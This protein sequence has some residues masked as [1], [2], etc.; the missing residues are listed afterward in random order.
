MT[1]IARALADALGSDRVATDA[2]SLAAHRTDYWILSHLRARQKRLG[3]GPACVVRP[4]STAEVA[5]A[6]VTA[7]RHGAAV[8][9]YGAGSGVLG[10][11]TPPEGSVVIDLRAMAAVLELNETALWVRVQ[12]GLMGGA[13]EAGLKA[14]GFTGAHFPQSIDVSTVGGWVSTRA[15]GQ[16]STRYGNIEDLLLALEAVLPDGQVVRTKNVPRAAAGP[17]LREV[18]CGSEGTF[19]IVTEVTLRIFPIPERREVASFVFADL[20]D[21]LETIRTVV[22]AGWRPPVLRLYDGTEALRQFS[23]WVPTDRA[24][25]LAVSEGPSAL[26]EGEMVAVARA[27]A[28]AGAQPCGPEPVMH[29]LEHRNRVPSW[30]LFLDKELLVDTIEI[31]ADWDRVAGLYDAVVKALSTVPGMVAASAHSSHSYAQG[32]N[33]Y[34]TFIVK[35]PDFARAEETYLA[36]WTGVME[37]TLAAGGTIAHHH[38]VGRLR[39]S[40]LARELGSAYPVLERLKR[41]LDPTGMM[42]PGVLVPRA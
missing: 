11:A 33:L 29:W 4:R 20:R 7:G 2:D 28:A 19:G 41:M 17:N 30:D 39:T 24:L 14:R 8:V 37:A 21:G 36:A 13:Y 1:D 6:L 15:A 22:R 32:T 38:G 35:P 42:N 25:L 18:F 34:I 23:E 12:A 3:T 31:A 9:P 40:W 26:V 10:G 16:F 27:A 5:S